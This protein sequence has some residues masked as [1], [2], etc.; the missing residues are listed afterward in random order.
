MRKYKMKLPFSC[1]KFCSKKYDLWC[2][3][4][5]EI[6]LITL[7][8]NEQITL[9][10]RLILITYSH[11]SYAKTIREIINRYNKLYRI[12]IITS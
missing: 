12:Q 5:K 6:E 7:G 11:K 9:S 1:K 8:E 10:D 4:F 3:F 2:S